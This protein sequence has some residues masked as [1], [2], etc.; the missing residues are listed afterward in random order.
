MIAASRLARAAS[1]PRRAGQARILRAVSARRILV[2][3]DDPLV[4]WSLAERLRDAG[5][6]IIEAGTGGEALELAEQGADLVLLDYKLPDEDGL[7]VLKK[8]RDLDPDTPVVMLTAHTSVDT[9]VEA[10]KAGAFDYATKPFDLDDMAL[11][12]TRA[13]EATRLRRE[14]RTLRAV[15]A[16]PHSLGSIIGES[17]VMQRV[18]TL[19]RKVASSPGSTVLLTGET[20]TGKD[21]VAKVVHYLSRR[22]DRPFLNITC[23]ALPEHLLESEMFGHEKGAFTDARQQKRGL[24]EQADEGTVFLDEIG[25]MTPALQAKLLRVLEEKAF[26]RVGGSGDVRVDVRV[27]AATNRDLEALVREG[28][29]RDDL[30]YRLNVLRVEL[31]PL[32]ARGADVTLLARHFVDTFSREFKR[33]VRGVSAAA[34]ATLLAYDW[35]GNARELR[36]VIERAVLLSESDTLHAPDLDGLHRARGSGSAF[37]GGFTL[38]RDGVRLDDVERSLVIQALERAD[39]VQTRAAALLG[40]HRDQMR[41]RIDKFGLK[42][43]PKEGRSARQQAGDPSALARGTASR[44]EQ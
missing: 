33:S 25:E 11:R 3:D 14:L 36:N 26:R 22:A 10:M 12:V 7:T 15:L 21:L 44:I 2:V 8:L 39:G 43:D 30:Y 29:F 19:V 32:R 17:E 34:E 24:I 23:S 9:I 5:H 41:Y 40:L 31:P 35:P 37:D 20:G 28:R 42:D 13:L 18:K 6:D 1:G 38:P 16:R 27:I 4:R